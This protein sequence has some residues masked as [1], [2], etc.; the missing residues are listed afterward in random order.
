MRL[1]LGQLLT[2]EFSIVEASGMMI[3][4]FGLSAVLGAIRQVLFNAQFGTGRE[5]NA[6]YAA[7]RLPDTLFSL[8]AGGALSSAMLP[9]LVATWR[10]QG[11]EWGQRLV[12]LV[13]STLLAVLSVVVLLGLIFAPSF[14]THVL[15][16]GFDAPTS[17]LTI[18]LTRIMLLEPLI[19]AVGAV[20]IAVL[21]GRNQ[22]L[23][24]ALSIISHN[25]TIISTCSSA[26][27]RTPAVGP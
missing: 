25:F 23:L 13:L 27:N 12:N 18:R 19:L 22:F 24:P 4:A 16:P 6:Y 9:V 8:I 15:A 10:V 11:E 5:A 1:R 20:S 17:Q 14:V 2:R 3:A 26:P 7:A 21:N